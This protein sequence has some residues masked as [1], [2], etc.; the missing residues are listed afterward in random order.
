MRASLDPRGITLPSLHKELQDRGL[1]L[2]CMEVAS[3]AVPVRAVG[4]G[5]ISR[6][7]I[8]KR[9]DTH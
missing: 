4:A 9:R 5:P 8:N 2:F 6:H 7:S 3:D 1:A